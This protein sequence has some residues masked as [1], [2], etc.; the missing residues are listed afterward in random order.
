MRWHYLPC[1]LVIFR[2]QDKAIVLLIIAEPFVD[3]IRLYSVNI[4]SWFSPT[5]NFMEAFLDMGLCVAGRII[6]SSLRLLNLTSWFAVCI[7]FNLHVLGYLSIWL[8]AWSGCVWF[9]ASLRI[10]RYRMFQTLTLALVHLL[11]KLLR[12]EILS[13]WVWRSFSIWHN[14]ALHNRW[15]KTF[16]IMIDGIER[17]HMLPSQTWT[18]LATN[19]DLLLSFRITVL[20]QQRLR[21]TFFSFLMKLLAFSFLDAMLTTA[22]EHL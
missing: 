17:P 2:L 3:I 15:V 8:E 18:D 10:R 22:S 11:K 4:S 14:V 19:S 13:S 9:T 6:Q 12:V 20:D 7:H 16:N 21:A 5:T 1:H